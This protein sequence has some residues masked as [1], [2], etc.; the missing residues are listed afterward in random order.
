M[1]MITSGS[2]KSLVGSVQDMYLRY[3]LPWVVG[4][5]GGKDST[6]VLQLVW[7]ALKG[8]EPSK[9]TKPVYVLSSDTGVEN[10][11]IKELI[12]ESI[13]R[14]ND[15]AAVEGLPIHAV[16][17]Q[18]E[19]EDGF[20]VNLIGRGYPAPTTRFR[21]C[22][23]RLKID[24]VSRFVRAKVAEFGEVIMV[25]GVRK[26]ESATRAQL[27]SA[28][29]VQ[30]HALRRH[31]TQ[32]GAY[33]Y[34]PIQD[35]SSDDVWAFL[36]QVQSPWGSS[37]RDLS[38]LYRSASGDECPLVVDTSTPSC[39][40]SRFG[41][42]V[43]TVASRDSSMASLVEDGQ[44]WLEPLLE[45]RD[46]LFDTTDPAKKRDYRDVRGRNGRIQV[47]R[48]GTLAAR[49][50][51]LQTSKRM[52][53]DIL[54]I[55]TLMQRERPEIELIT[56]VEL[57]EVRRIWVY[58]RHDWE[59]SL[60]AIVNAAL[61][62]DAQ[63]PEFDDLQFDLEYL[64]ILKSEAAGHGVP[65]ALLTKLIEAERATSLTGRRGI[66]KRIQKLVELDWRSENEILG[67]YS[68]YLE[69]NA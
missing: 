40:K 56:H 15:A 45:F 66:Y 3:P 21:W 14:I 5:S 62:Q 6:A 69:A 34:A 27:M 59:D 9:L 54:Q 26:E 42:W 4:F 64:E 16:C 19:P 37:N 46:F 7:A 25:L 51:T 65:L 49:S 1:S 55:Q 13:L 11:L 12:E 60:P 10:P 53:A 31:S 41:C 47:K 28:H 67:A 33:V 18:P 61:G 23:E 63:W 35:W 30:G 29:E 17:V 8:I 32:T 36:L 52:L 22:T 39:G 57:Q 20:W 68:D 24:P 38:A 50:Y 43:C 2:I 58:E 44:L 48:D